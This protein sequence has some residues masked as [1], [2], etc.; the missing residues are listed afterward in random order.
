[1]TISAHFLA[2]TVL[3]TIWA[4]FFPKPWYRPP[5]AN[6]HPQFHPLPTRL[7]PWLY[8]PPRTWPPTLMCSFRQSVS[9]WCW[10][11]LLHF[12]PPNLCATSHPATFFPPGHP[13]QQRLLPSPLA[14][15]T[16]MWRT[17][18]PP[19]RPTP[20][21]ST[22]NNTHTVTLIRVLHRGTDNTVPVLFSKDEKRKKTPSP[23]GS[24][25]LTGRRKPPSPS[26]RRRP[27]DLLLHLLFFW[28]K[29]NLLIPG[30]T[31]VLWY[32]STVCQ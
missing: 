9:C 13:L 18:I 26:W 11:G 10:W 3:Y 24:P 20:R 1:M 15:L 19:H 14:I 6:L 7:T 25:P 22:L 8:P 30:G 32:Q 29:I 12:P 27:C 28:R 4:V 21:S 2:M 17:P 5:L 23:S 16:S 31:S